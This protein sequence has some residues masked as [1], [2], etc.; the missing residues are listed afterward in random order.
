MKK[1]DVRIGATYRA[2]VSDKLTTIRI[3]AIHPSGG[4]GATNL[5]TG[6][7]IHVKSVQ[8]LRG[9]ATI[10]GEG[11]TE[12]HDERI[13]TLGTALSDGQIAADTNV[14]ISGNQPHCQCR[15]P[16]LTEAAIA[17]LRDVDKPMTCTQMIEQILDRKLWSGAGK[18]PVRT[19][20][21][22]ILHEIKRKG[23]ASRFVKVE[24]GK[25]TLAK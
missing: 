25:F 19:L 13:Q 14:V 4:W 12:K 3:D 17:V 20:Y 7:P 5:T 9:P 10:A 11:H 24:R 22:S 6:K 16:S 8:R 23:D 1:S 21:A 15:R 18:T 2:K